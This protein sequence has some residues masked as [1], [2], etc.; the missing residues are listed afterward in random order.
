MLTRCGPFGY[1]VGVN[2]F[3]NLQNVKLNYPIL[4]DPVTSL[5]VW[6]HLDGF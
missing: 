3:R 4:R 1:S 6:R 5:D 2:S